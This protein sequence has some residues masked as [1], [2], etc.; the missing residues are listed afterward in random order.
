MWDCRVADRGGTEVLQVL[1]VFK[2]GNG[3]ITKITAC[4]GFSAAGSS[5]RLRTPGMP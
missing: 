5:A 2:Q 4:C 3:M 1:A